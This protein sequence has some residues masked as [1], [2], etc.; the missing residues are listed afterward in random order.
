MQVIANSQG[1]DSFLVSLDDEALELLHKLCSVT[2]EPP[3][4][5]IER[6][7]LGGIVLQ[8]TINR[9]IAR[10]A[11]PKKRNRIVSLLRITT[12]FRK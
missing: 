7:V 12:I 8:D 11:K 6:L 1:T 9:Q 2:G 4:K 5:I 10:D 3:K